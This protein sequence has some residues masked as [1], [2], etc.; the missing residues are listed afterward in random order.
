[1][2]GDLRQRVA[3]VEPGLAVPPE[4]VGDVGHGRAGEGA[5]SA[6]SVDQRQPGAE[7]VAGEPRVL[8]QVDRREAT[9]AGGQPEPG[10][11]VVLDA[12][13]DERD[14]LV[15]LLDPYDARLAQPR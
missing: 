3:A 5:P 8:A 14:A 11:V 12:L 2:L 7:L 15:V 6:A 1:M 4:V 13:V 9:E 10:R